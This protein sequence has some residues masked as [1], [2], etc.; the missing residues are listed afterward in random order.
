MKKKTFPQFASKRQADRYCKAHDNAAAKAM[1]SVDPT[2]A[3]HPM[4]L[5]QVVQLD[6][7][8]GDF[9]SISGNVPDDVVA[10]IIKIVH[11]G[12]RDGTA[13]TSLTSL[14]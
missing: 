4:V 11:E 3:S 9:V 10:A 12:I 14:K 5:I 6:G 2:T 13:A 8:E 1:Q 7:D